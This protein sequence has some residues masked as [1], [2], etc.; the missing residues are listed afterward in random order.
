MVRTRFA[1]YIQSE[2]RQDIAFHRDR[3]LATPRA[4]RRFPD[5]ATLPSTNA[6]DAYPLLAASQCLRSF[7]CLLQTLDH[8][9]DQVGVQPGGRRGLR[10]GN[11]RSDRH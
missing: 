1:L 5:P 4:P 7:Q 11:G 2:A 3:S 9:A 8:G 10:T 6:W